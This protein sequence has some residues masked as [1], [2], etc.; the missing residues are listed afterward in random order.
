MEVQAKARSQLFE[1]ADSDVDPPPGFNPLIVFVRKAGMFGKAFLREARFHSKSPQASLDEGIW[2]DVAWHPAR[3]MPSFKI[4]TSSTLVFILAGERKHVKSLATVLILSF[5][6]N[7]SAVESLDDASMKCDLEVEVKNAELIDAYRVDL[8]K[9]Q[10]DF[11]KKGDLQNTL[12]VKNE[13]ERVATEKRLGDSNLISNPPQLHDL[14]VKHIAAPRKLSESISKSWIAKLEEAKR[15][16]TI[17]GKLDEAVVMQKQ[18]DAI[19]KKYSVQNPSQ[20]AELDP[21][22]LPKYVTLTEAAEFSI[23]VD[24]ERIGVVGVQKGEIFRLLKVE[25]KLVTIKTQAGRIITVPI[26]STDLMKRIAILMKGSE[27]EQEAMKQADEEASGAVSSG[28]V[29]GSLKVIKATYGAPTG[30]GAIVDIT[31]RLQSLVTGNQLRVQGNSST[32]AGHD[33]AGGVLKETRITYS[34]G[35]KKKEAF[36]IEGALIV[37]P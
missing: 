5:A 33:P 13:L 20:A 17:D 14:Q 10:N 3:I 28:S 26:D 32:L 12:I 9:L 24:G 6:C 11:Q 23:L 37:L 4:D 29:I 2:C 35:G 16:L 15:K 34:I 8:G 36:F 1:G 30:R 31:Q 18:V 22:K 19:M 27:E 21:A 7:L 25:G